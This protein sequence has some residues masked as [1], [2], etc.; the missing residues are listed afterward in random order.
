MQNIQQF[1]RFIYGELSPEE[2][3]KF[4][5]RLKTDKDFATDFKAYILTVAGICKEAQQDDIE[6]ATAMKNITPEQLL[7]IM[8]YRKHS[9][10]PAQT[11]DAPLPGVRFDLAIGF[12]E[13][14]PVFNATAS[15]KIQE[16]RSKIDEERS[17]ID[18]ERLSHKLEEELPSL[19]GCYIDLSKNG[20]GQKISEI[21]A[22]VT[23]KSESS[24][25]IRSA[26]TWSAKT[27]IWQAS[28]IA[29][30]VLIAFIV[31]LDF[32]K[33]GRE[34]VDNVVFSFYADDLSAVSRG[35]DDTP[36]GSDGQSFTL[37][38]YTSDPAK[39]IPVLIKKYESADSPQDIAIYGKLLALAYIKA[40]DRRNARIVL[41]TIIDKLSAYSPDWDDTISE[42]RT[43]LN[44]VG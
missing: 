23:K 17:K 22:P 32:E 16:E 11:D 12:G 30:V 15:S 42:C 2:R 20:K 29:A 21:E 40:H 18:E 9:P 31:V 26:K 8:G 19:R 1:D 24:A 6:F 14:A 38:A 37:E 7:E 28:S 27:W 4:I 44:A 33:R 43:I 5:S 34:N 10:F 25:K 13:S 41:Q 39:A 3:K 36:I 35:G